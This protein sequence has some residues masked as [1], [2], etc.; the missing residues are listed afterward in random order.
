MDII[1]HLPELRVFHIA[2]ENLS[3]TSAAK[4]LFL[5]QPAVSHTIKEL[6]RQYG[7][8]LFIRANRKIRLTSQGEFLFQLCEKIFEAVRSQQIKLDEHFKVNKGELKFSATQT[9]VKYS[10]MSAVK[11][12]HLSN[13]EAVF[14]IQ[15]SSKLETYRLVSFGAVEFGFVTTPIPVG[16]L[17]IG[18][19]YLK[20]FDIEDVFV[21]NSDRYA[22][23]STKLT[24]DDI[25]SNSLITLGKNSL[26]HRYQKEF[27]ERNNYS[28]TPDIEC[29]NLDLVVEFVEAD[30]GIGWI[31]EA[32]LADAIQKGRKIKK[33]DFE[34][35][36]PK[37]EIGVIFKADKELSYLAEKFVDLVKSLKRT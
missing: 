10:L 7:H 22:D 19:K 27:F 24:F 1:N 31:T 21:G 20:L 15:S 13:P 32:V 11:E 18:L 26:S 37:R 12:F 14:K 30:L 8:K 35:S 29:D 5:T 16:A 6:E 23:S 28:L 25:C 33:L 4:Q 36:L 17:S 9:I 3:M 2:A 34:P